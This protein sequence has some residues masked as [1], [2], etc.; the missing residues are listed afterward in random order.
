MSVKGDNIMAHLTLEDRINIKVMLDSNYPITKIANELNKANSTISREIKKHSKPSD[1]VHYHRVPNRC[2]NKTDCNKSYLC[3]KHYSICK[4][5]KCSICRECNDVCTD[6]IEE[7]CSKLEKSPHV[8]NGCKDEL[9]CTLIKCFYSPTI[10]DDE[11]RST[12]TEAREGANLTETEHM[13]IDELFSPLLINGQSIHHIWINN[14]NKMIR[15]EKSIYRYI[16]ANLLSAKNIDL[17]RVVRRR[18]RKTKPIQCKIDK[19]C[20][21][22]RTYDDFK[23]YLSNN[24]GL[25][26][27]EMDTVEGIKGGKVLLTLHFKGLCDLMLS[28]IRDNNTAQSVI[29][30][31]DYLYK[32]LGKEL[33]NKLFGCILTDRGT[34]FSNPKALESAPDG[35]SRCKI[36]YCDPQA[37]WQKPNVELNHEFIRRVLPKGKSFNHLVQEDIDLMM[38]N[39]NSYKREKLNNHSPIHAM[40]SLFGQEILEKLNIS[41]IQPDDIILS[42]KLLK[43]Y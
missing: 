38:N 5:K 31:F 18:P 17:P 25:Q 14:K 42:P 8:C 33:F 1:K 4:K 16:D 9:K 6:F 37:A 2:I 22:N 21:I 32:R 35:S 7:K 26:V 40:S 39:I 15:S 30:I 13:Y 41:I 10:A 11:Y 29:D 24:P 3:S 23:K 43:K 19:L 36:F 27:V 20:Y 34:E 12:L 28:F